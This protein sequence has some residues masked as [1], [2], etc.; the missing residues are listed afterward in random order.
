MLQVG[1]SM[2][3]LV[4]NCGQDDVSGFVIRGEDDILR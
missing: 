2:F 3:H 4:S 1:S